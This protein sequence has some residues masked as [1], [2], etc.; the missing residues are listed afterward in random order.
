MLGANSSS[1]D[2]AWISYVDFLLARLALLGQAQAHAGSP[3]RCLVGCKQNRI[4]SATHRDFQRMARVLPRSTAHAL[5]LLVP[6]G[7][8][9]LRSREPGE[10]LAPRRFVDL[11]TRSVV[12]TPRRR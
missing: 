5:R 2:D 11:W 7:L 10:V 6:I 4:V 3:P 12:R 8:G 9:A 1:H